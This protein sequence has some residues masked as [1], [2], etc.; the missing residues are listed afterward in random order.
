M[1]GTNFLRDT[2]VLFFSNVR[3]SKIID[4]SSFTMINMSHDAY[5]RWF[6][7]SLEFLCRGEIGSIDDADD[8]KLLF[9]NNI[10]FRVH[11]LFS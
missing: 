7:F 2:T 11:H 3:I 6:F 5:N 9:R 8:L 10:I 1:E 4:E